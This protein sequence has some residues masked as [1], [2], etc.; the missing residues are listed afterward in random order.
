MEQQQCKDCIYYI[1]HYGKSKKKFKEINC[2]HCF[3]KL[4]KSDKSC[5]SFTKRDL[6]KENTEQEKTTAE[7]LANIE[8]LL[9]EYKEIIS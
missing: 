8:K 9:K 1:Q 7:Y 5:K 2:W 6:K 4:R 3:K